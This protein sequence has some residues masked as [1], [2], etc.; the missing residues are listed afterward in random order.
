[1]AREKKPTAAVVP[2][3]GDG[4]GEAGRCCSGSGGVQQR[5]WRRGADAAEG[6][7]SGATVV[8][9]RSKAAETAMR[10]SDSGARCG[11]G[12]RRGRKEE[13]AGRSDLGF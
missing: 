11:R 7:G 4:N 13:R 6:D 2:F 12:R 5:Q 1:M 3:S 8:A 9:D 10:R